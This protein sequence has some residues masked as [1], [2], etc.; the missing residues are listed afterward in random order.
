MHKYHSII[1]YYYE[2]YEYEP[3]LMILP[4]AETDPVSSLLL[5]SEPSI[6]KLYSP[7]SSGP[8]RSSATISI[9]GP[10]LTEA[11]DAELEPDDADDS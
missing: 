6:T 5:P 9:T 11:E 8:D 10:E 7:V 2:T 4:E 1:V 3:V